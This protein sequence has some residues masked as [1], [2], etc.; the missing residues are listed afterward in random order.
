M[1]KANPTHSSPT[2]YIPTPKKANTAQCT[3]KETTI[4]ITK[5]PYTTMAT[6]AYT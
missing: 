6:M 1:E 4:N 5:T 3:L 2:Y